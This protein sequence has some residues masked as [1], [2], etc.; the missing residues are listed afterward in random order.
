VV[1]IDALQ[2]KQKHSVKLPAYVTYQSTNLLYLVDE[3]SEKANNKK[4]AAQKSAERAEK[5]SR[6]KAKTEEI[7]RRRTNQENQRLYCY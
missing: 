5:K 7:T 6:K 2:K 1:A 4:V 3:A